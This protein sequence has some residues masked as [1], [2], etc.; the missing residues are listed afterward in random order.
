MRKRIA[1]PP[2]G[3][4]GACWGDVGIEWVAVSVVLFLFGVAVGY[5]WRD[6]I[7]RARRLRYL[8][9][10]ARRHVELDSVATAIAPRK[11]KEASR[12]PF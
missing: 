2:L 11:M 1:A 4:S 10:Q 8:V 5:A 9:E 12:R 7:S 3:V 6:R